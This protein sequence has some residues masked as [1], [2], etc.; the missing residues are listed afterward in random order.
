MEGI[1]LL[2]EQRVGGRM[3]AA[4]VALGRLHV[5]LRLPHEVGSDATASADADHGQPDHRVRKEAQQQ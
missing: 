4:V 2:A 5:R 1:G 3:V